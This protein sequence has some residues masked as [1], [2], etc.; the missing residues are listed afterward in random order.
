MD[1][2]GFTAA[3]MQEIEDTTIVDGDIVGNDLIL[4]PRNAA[5]IN[6]GNVRGPQGAQ[7]VQGPPGA[8]PT[9]RATHNAAQTLT[10]A[11]GAALALNSEQFDTDVMHDTVTNNSRITIKTAGKYQVSAVVEFIANAAG[12]RQIAIVVNGVTYIAIQTQQ[13]S[14]GNTTVLSVSTLYNFAVNDYIEVFAY[15]NSGG[16]LDVKTGTYTPIL[17]AGKISS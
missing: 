2:T 7:G 1:V 16:N 9:C 12:Y 10:T 17:T 6:A 3:R 13:P 15:Q 14:A 8:V 11:V 5:D 4:H